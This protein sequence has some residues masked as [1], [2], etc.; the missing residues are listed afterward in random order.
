MKIVIPV[1]QSDAHLLNGVVDVIKALGGVQRHEILLLPTRSFTNQAR[2]AA[3]RLKFSCRAIS[4]ATWDS[5]NNTGTWPYPGNVMWQHAVIQVSKQEQAGNSSPWYFFEL[6]NTPLVPGWADMIEANYAVSGC[7]FMGAVVPTRVKIGDNYTTDRFIP[8]QPENIPHMVGTGVYPINVNAATQGLWKFPKHEVP[9]D[10]YLRYVMSRSLHGTHLIDHHWSTINYR[11]V[12]GEI[13][14]DN[15][16]KNPF[17][18]DHSGKIKKDAVVVHG[19]KDGSLAKIV[20]Q[21]YKVSEDQPDPQ[22][23]QETVASVEKKVDVVVP[24]TPSPQNFKLDKAAFAAFNNSQV[25]TEVITKKR[26]RPKK[27]EATTN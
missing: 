16:P 21:K 13:V 15:D 25:R 11:E 10:I 3:E 1:S 22:P 14:C 27:T 17:G 18:T 9:W 7:K 8:G 12:N 20:L 24:A 4:V 5:D 26:G 19:C 2:E 23:V 6:D